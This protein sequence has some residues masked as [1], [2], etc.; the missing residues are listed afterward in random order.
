M[1]HHVFQ[2][3]DGIVHDHTHRDGK[4]HQRD[5]IEGIPHKIESDKGSYNGERYGQG[6]DH[7]GPK[8]AQKEEAYNDDQ[9]SAH[10]CRFG[11]VFDHGMNVVGCV[12]D[13]MHLDICRHLRLQGY[14]PLFHGIYNVD[15]VGARLFLDDHYHSWKAAPPAPLGRFLV[16]VLHLGHI[17]QTY[18]RITLMSNYDAGYFS[19]ILEASR[20][21]DLEFLCTHF[22]SAG[23][24]VEIFSTKYILYLLHGKVV[25]LQA[26]TVEMHRNLSLYAPLIEDCPYTGH[27]FQRIGQL[28]V[29]DPVKIGTALLCRYSHHEHRHHGAAELEDKRLFCAIR[30]VRLCKIDF[31]SDVVDRNVQVS[32]PVEYAVDNGYVVLRS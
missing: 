25:G 4:T 26:L 14:Q 12:Q 22:D 20:H 1:P 13:G 5:N 3:H 9:H 27:T 10:E 32:T 23:W 17:S 16:R 19:S 7:A 31:L 21:P 6:H 24:E 8:T 18:K 15:A 2:D 11:Q 28:L 30:K 29:Y